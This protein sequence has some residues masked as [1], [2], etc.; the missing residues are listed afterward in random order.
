MIPARRAGSDERREN[1]AKKH[2]TATLPCHDGVAVSHGSRLF[3]YSGTTRIESL[4]STTK[5]S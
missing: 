2:D 1:Q 5:P 3:G 4:P